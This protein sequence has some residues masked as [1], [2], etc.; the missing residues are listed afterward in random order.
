MPV[1]AA[2]ALLMGTAIHAIQ[3]GVSN[4]GLYYGGSGLAVSVLAAS[5]LAQKAG[6]AAAP[7]KRA[8]Y[9]GWKG[10]ILAAVGGI[11]LGGYPLL[12]ES[13]RA[14]EIGL[15]PYTAVVFLTLGALLTT[16]LYNLY[17]L[18]LPVQGEALPLAAYFQGG[19]KQHLLGVLGGTLWVLGAIALFGSAGNTFAEAPKTAAVMAAGCGAA[20]VGALAGLTVW[21]EGTESGKALPMAAALLLAGAV[22][23]QFL[24]A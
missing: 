12:M 9:A 19:A 1:A 20:V 3:G 24:G 5:F 10:Y 21:G 4:A 23:A 15:G 13:S 2:V 17:F 18:N 22:A 16:P 14:G 8:M 6:A 7:R 11:F